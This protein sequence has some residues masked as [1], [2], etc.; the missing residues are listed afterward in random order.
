[1]NVLRP[2]LSIVRGRPHGVE[3]GEAE[4]ED[5]EEEREDE[6]EEEEEV[7]DDIAP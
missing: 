5:E 2:S 3:Q 1:M 7:E 4:D 6:E